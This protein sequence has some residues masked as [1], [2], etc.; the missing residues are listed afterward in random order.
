VIMAP[1]A[2]QIAS[3]TGSSPHALMMAVIAAAGTTFTPI[4]NPVN[5]LIMGPGGYRMKDYVRI[6]LPLALLLWLVGLIVIPIIGRL[7]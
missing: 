6:G 2:L 3:A 4:S 1:I 7:R 5:L